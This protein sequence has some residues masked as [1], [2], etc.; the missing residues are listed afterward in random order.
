MSGPFYFTGIFYGLV[1]CFFEQFLEQQGPSLVL[2]MMNPGLP[3]RN[4]IFNRINQKRDV[5]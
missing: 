2:T 1:L 4:E 3:L 5:G